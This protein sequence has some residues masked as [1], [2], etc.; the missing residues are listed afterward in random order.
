MVLAGHSSA[1]PGLEFSS[2]AS[3]SIQTLLLSEELWSHEETVGTAAGGVLLLAK[4]G[5][6]P[7]PCQRSRLPQGREGKS[8]AVLDSR[9]NGNQMVD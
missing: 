5:G 2:S 8:G 4:A 7:A 6:K 3:G 9:G 1:G